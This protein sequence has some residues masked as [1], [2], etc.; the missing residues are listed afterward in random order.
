MIVG[1]T[2]PIDHK[3]LTKEGDLMNPLYVGIDV[4]SRAN[5][6]Y[7]MKPDGSRHSNFSVANSLDG[8]RQLVKRILSA[9][10]SE[11]L[12]DVIIGL[13]ATSVYGDNLVCFLR[14]D[15]SLNPY[16]KRIH[17]LN[18][19]QVNK[20]KQAYNDL[21]KNDYVDSF[22]IAD[23]LRFGR[24]NKEVYLDD[25]RYKALQNLT[26]ARFFAVQNLVKEKQ[27]FLNY[28][29]KKYST[30]AQEK[31]FSDT[32][33]TSA[34]AVY[35]EFD[36]AETLANMDLQQLT[37]FLIQKG[38]NR[39]PDPESVAKAIQKAARSSY[40]LPKTI[41]DSVNQVLSI[42]ISS[43][44]ALESQIKAFDKAIAAQMEL[45]PNT[46]TSVNGIGPV[47]SAGIIAEIGDINRFPNQ[48][49]LAKYAGLVWSQH[50]S[51]DFEAQNTR[52]IKS[53]NRYL[54]YY[55][56]EAAMSLVRCDA[57]YSRFY[58]LKYK[59]VNKYQH[60]RALALTARKFVRLV[61][62]LLKDNCL[63]RAPETH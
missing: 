16:N 60:K 43:M 57:E 62:R 10:T 20:F 63:Y 35:E 51:G 38:K 13:E 47:Y 58:H 26:R 28:L 32:F 48:A 25:Y 59:E 31:V 22:V 40:R 54:K 33:S 5:V 18:P 55:L 15:G 11:S 19:K 36:S 12:S 49:A 52:L 24:I 30:M 9:I 2:K 56:C 21:P 7:L 45:I 44:K 17:V 34:L 6:A 3:F 37:D 46:L 42:S 41:N 50:Q 27:R 29:F 14:E 4:S 61:F 8:S 23:C 39:F 1:I 53:G